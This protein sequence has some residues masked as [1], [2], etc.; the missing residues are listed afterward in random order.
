MK[1]TGDDHTTRRQA[2][3]LQDGIG[4]T[5]AS[6]GG[7][8]AQGPVRN[9][10]LAEYAARLEVRVCPDPPRSA[11]LIQNPRLREIREPRRTLEIASLLSRSRQVKAMWSYSSLKCGST[12]CRAKLRRTRS[13]SRYRI[14]GRSCSR[15]GDHACTN[16]TP[17]NRRS[18]RYLAV[19]VRLLCDG[20]DWC[21][22]DHHHREQLIP[23]IPVAASVRSPEL[24][25][26]AR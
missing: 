4:D 21:P 3:L 23:E 26:T 18:D 25:S 10:A 11:R 1:I 20:A 5:L 22:R 7:S 6:V 17:I 19:T 8:S 16:R 9:L 12:S 2:N 24:C 13:Q 14:S 15:C